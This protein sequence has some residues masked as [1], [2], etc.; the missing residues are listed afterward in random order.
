[1]RAILETGSL[2]GAARSIDRAYSTVRNRMTRLK[3]KLGTNSVY[4][5]FYRLGRG[6]FD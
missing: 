4:E 5:L 3:D 1:M 2:F 6:D